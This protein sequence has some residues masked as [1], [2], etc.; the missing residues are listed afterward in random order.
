MR[1][2]A[3]LLLCAVLYAS[4]GTSPTPAPSVGNTEAAIL[5]RETFGD[6]W[7]FT[8]PSG[9]VRCLNPSGPGAGEVVFIA[10]GTT[11]AVNGIAEQAGT[12]ADIAPIW[13]DDPSVAGL[14]IPIGPI[15]DAGLALCT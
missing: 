6:A 1:R 2:F 12:Y 4:C 10:N 3:L 8:V 11:Y 14:K 5:S 13:R 7:P 9:E 15:L